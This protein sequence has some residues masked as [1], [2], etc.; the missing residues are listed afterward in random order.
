MA[1][2]NGAD[3]PNFLVILVDDMGF[4]DIGAFGS[5]I[6]TPYLD[7]LAHAGVRFTDFHSAPACSPTR[8]MLLTG[9]DHHIAGLGSMVEVVRPDFDRP[10]GYE[11]YLNDRVVTFVEL[12]RDAGYRT[13]MSGKWHL[14]D[15]PATVPAARGFERSFALLPGGADHFGGS[16]LDRAVVRG[17]IYIEDETFVTELPEG[18]YSSDH[19]TTRLLDFLEEGRGDERPF[20][21][22]L[23]FSAPHWPLQAPDAEIAK[24]RGRYDDGPD[25]LRAR[26]L[27]RLKDLGLI[28]EDVVPHPVV[29]EAPEWDALSDAERADSAR[30]MEVYAAMVDRID[31]NVGRVVDWL[32]RNGRF[33]NTVI[34]FLSDN[35][36]E[37]AIVEAMPIIGPLFSQLIREHCDNSLA[38]AGK[39]GSYIWYGPRWAQAATAPSRL[40]KAYTTEGGIRVPA[41]IHYP[42]AARAGEVSGEFATVMDV[43]PTFLDL[44]GV[45]HPG[46]SYQGRPIA[47]VRGRSFAGWLHAG[48]DRI[49]PP[50]TSTGWELFGRRAI[51]KDHWKAVYVPGADGRS[52]WQLYDLAIDP[53]ETDDLARAYPARLEELLA[54]WRRY[55]EETGVVEDAISIFDADPEAWAQARP[56]QAAA[57]PA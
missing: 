23:P 7:A 56:L 8:A 9:T 13:L 6:E 15:T 22:Y 5:E 2:K 26:R 30:A 47:P 18:F 38:N 4:S 25:A 39:P 53:G 20:F 42:A 28:A 19:F 21:A 12:L 10:P 55:V 51:R 33:D 46:E 3:R 52:R 24:Y 31:Q 17:P 32:K 49:H 37:G 54:L 29:T 57:A 35:G 40:T 1:V 36:A 43:A 50:G 45:A 27:D 14:G 11:G 48:A 34:L 44:A 41:F 16:P